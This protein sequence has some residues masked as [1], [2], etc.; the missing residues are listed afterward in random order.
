MKLFS[1]NLTLTAT[2]ASLAFVGLSLAGC[3]T[4]EPTNPGPE[5]TPSFSSA[6]E[7]Q[8]AFAECMRG[9]GIDMPDPGEG[10]QISAGS[11]DLYLEAAETC[12]DELGA[13]P[14][15]SGDE[16]IP[17]E[18]EQH[19]IFLRMAECFR[20]NGI[21]IPDPAVGESLSIPMDADQ[22]VLKECATQGTSVSQ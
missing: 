12:Q 5:D 15:G 7:Y 17:S 3:S 21:E 16:G 20:D 2:L 1:R 18:A 10:G 6:E 19:E 9:K 13:P 22:D 14:A 11:G 8:L 4:S